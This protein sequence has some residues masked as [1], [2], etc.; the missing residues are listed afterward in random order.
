MSVDKVCCLGWGGRE[1][2]EGGEARML[3]GFN[4]DQ[5][6]MVKFEEPLL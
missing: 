4:N 3:N 1:L 2:C 6:Q 5:I